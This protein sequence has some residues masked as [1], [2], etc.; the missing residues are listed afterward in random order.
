M[1]IADFDIVGSYNNQRITP[2]DGERS[3]NLFQYNDPLAK[4]SKVLIPTS[5]LDVVT[6]FVNTTGGFRASFLFNNITCHIIGDKFWRVQ[7]IGTSF[8]PSLINV[9]LP[10]TTSAGFVGIDANTFQI[11]FV[12]GAHGYIYDTNTQVF[13][14]ITDPSFP[15]NPIDVTY[16]D[17]FF[18]VA[19]GGTNN[20]YLSSFNQGLV[21]GPIVG[22]NPNP[23]TTATGSADITLTSGTTLSYQIGTPVQIIAS[24]DANFPTGNYFVVAVISPT[25][26][27][28]SATNGGTAITA[29]G[30]NGGTLTNNGQLQVGSITTHPGTIVACRTLHRRLFLFSQFFTEVWENLGVGTTLP[31]RRNNSLL[32]EYGT[33]AIGSV[34]VG[35]DTMCFLSQTRDGLGS[36]MQVVGTQALPVSTKALDF[37]LA[38]YNA[39]STNPPTTGVTDC[40]GF[41]M[42]ENAIIFYRMNF[43]LANHTFV[44]NITQSDPSQEDGRL[45]HEEEVL[46]G[47]RHPSQTHVF[48]NG[49]NLV[50]NYAL[51]L[52][53]EVDTD[54]YT[55]DGEHIRRMRIPRPYVPPGYQRIR[56]NRFQV[57]LL[58]GQIQQDI[59]FDTENL[60]TEGMAEILTEDG[61][62]ITTDQL[63]PVNIAN[64]PLV[65]LSIS[66]D[67]GQ[68]YGSVLSAPMGQIGERT[69][70]TLW[71][72]LGTTVRGQS[73][74]VKMEFFDPFPFYVMGAAWDYE[75]LPE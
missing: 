37:Q 42:R 32:M 9:S 43:T 10:L 40:R 4:K 73:F 6:T 28:L 74:V 36:V 12:D 35:F 56:I 33:A 39:I 16:L 45:W 67:G 31:F 46:N 15:A 18:I 26:I 14:I 23:F 30:N 3:V 71:R 72:K 24:T 51:P 59:M 69:F 20:F 61:N 68:T 2:I 53:Y 70:R 55:N 21:W 60:L 48:Y 54:L 41:L 63:F 38:R 65:F 66:K 29:A 19:D 52:L 62:N 75:V 13:T 47:D 58:Q 22:T 17:G 34:S 49:V 7:Q 27:H 44:Y 57:D 50:G 11:I 64:D 1:T 8:V 5:G 25:V